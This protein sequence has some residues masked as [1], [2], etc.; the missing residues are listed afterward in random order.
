MTTGAV[1]AGHP[2]TAQTGADVLRD[3]GNAVDAAI[4]S[5][6]TSF[7]TE[8]PMTGLGAGGFMLVH[9]PPESTLLDFFVETPGR[10]VAAPTEE[11]IPVAIGFDDTDQVFNIGAAS[12]GVPGTAAGL[13]EAATRFGSVPLSRLAAPAIGLARDGVVV[14]ADQAY[15]LA[16]LE[17]LHSHHAETKALYGPGGKVLG[18][19]DVFRF[20]ALADALER[21]A[22]EG[23][24]PFYRGDIAALVSEWVLERGPRGPGGL[25]GHCPRSG[26]GPVSRPRCPQQPASVLGRRSDCVCTRRT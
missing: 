20:P 4:C 19:G 8:S 3:G 2:I 23:A 9:D 22:D 7:V 25:R 17:S 1:A 12:C 16:L 26:G 18:E 21:L 5:V 15:V 24:E 14:N 13:V 6:L 11:L 10:V